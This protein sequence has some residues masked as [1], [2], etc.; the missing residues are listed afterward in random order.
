[1]LLRIS[2]IERKE[3]S[4][5]VSTDFG[6]YYASL[7]ST[8][9]EQ[10]VGK[11]IDAETSKSSDGR[12]NFLNGFSVVDGVKSAPEVVVGPFGSSPV[13]GPMMVASNDRFWAPFVSNTVAHCIQA[14]LIKTVSDL[15]NWAAAAYETAQRLDKGDSTPF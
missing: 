10:C 7:K 5:K 6:T 15:R 12:I 11:Q 8:G 13:A 14:G 1:M 3:K 9:I 2:N 4:Y